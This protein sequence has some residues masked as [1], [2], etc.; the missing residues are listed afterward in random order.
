MAN[1]Y[2]VGGTAN[3]DATAGTKWALTSGGAGGQAV[4]TTSDNV[5]F[6]ANSGGVTVTIPATPT[7]TAANLDFTGF[8]GTFTGGSSGVVQL[9]GDLLLGTGMTYSHSGALVFSI[10]SGSH[11]ITTHGVTITSAI[12]KNNA[13][14]LIMN[15]NLTAVQLSINAGSFLTNGFSIICS[16]GFSGGSGSVATVDF[17]SA[18]HLFSGSFNTIHG[19]FIVTPFTGI[20]KMVDSSNSNIYFQG[21]GQTY[22]SVWFSRGSSTGTNYI[23]DTGNTFTTLKDDGTAAHSFL[24]LSGSTTTI[25]NFNISGTLGNLITIGSCNT[26]GTPQTTT[27]TLSAV[28]G[29]I[30]CNYLNIQHSV[31]TGGATWYAG[32]NSVNNQ[33]VTTAGSGWIFTSP[34][35][36]TSFFEFM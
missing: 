11:T 29:I 24:F 6:D 19:S 26:S 13:G 1:R 33:A 5:F 34:P 23:Q 22:N 16:T 4:P 3:W 8:I 17:S 35:N 15:D 32:N 12:N 27:H 10:V 20:I 28:S 14:T 2:W 36:K 25:T 30:N 21:S 18:I 9:L 31:A 7:A